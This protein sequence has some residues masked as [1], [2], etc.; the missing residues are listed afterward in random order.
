[1]GVIVIQAIEGISLEIIHY[2][3]SQVV[4]LESQAQCLTEKQGQSMHKF[5]RSNQQQLNLQTPVFFY[6]LGVLTPDTNSPNSN[7]R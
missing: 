4:P 1:M 7:K 2:V 6:H 5:W 3:M